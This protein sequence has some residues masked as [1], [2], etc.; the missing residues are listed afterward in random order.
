MVSLAPYPHFFRILTP[1][2]TKKTLD[3]KNCKAYFWDIHLTTWQP[4]T[5]FLFPKI[6]YIKP[7]TV[8]VELVVAAQGRQGPSAD[9][10]GKE[11]LR[12]RVD[13]TF[14]RVKFWPENMS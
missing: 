11:D 6:L 5:C 3:T 8:M 14:G 2:L 9:G 10:V 12:G 13:P 1:D 4:W 7:E